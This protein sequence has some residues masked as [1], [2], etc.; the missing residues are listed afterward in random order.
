MAFVAKTEVSSKYL[1][2]I[3]KYHNLLM[4]GNKVKINLKDYISKLIKSCFHV[5]KNYIKIYCHIDSCVEKCLLSGQIFSA[6][7]EFINIK[8]K[9][10]TTFSSFILFY[11]FIF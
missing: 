4:F 5:Y 10:I 9:Q 6:V 11:L 2:I 8:L 1:L 3:G 7:Q